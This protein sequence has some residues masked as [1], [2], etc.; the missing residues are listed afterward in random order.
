MGG[1]H[2]G[3]YTR[4]K[5]SEIHKDFAAHYAKN[6]IHHPHLHYSGPRGLFSSQSPGSYEWGTNQR[7][8]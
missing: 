4:K 2:P 5:F 1:F 8:N 7:T 3:K 6:K